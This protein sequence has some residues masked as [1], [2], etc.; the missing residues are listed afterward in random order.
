MWLAKRNSFNV[1]YTNPFSIAGRPTTHSSL[2]DFTVRGNF[3]SKG[4]DV[5]NVG[6]NIMGEYKDNLRV[7]YDGGKSSANINKKTLEKSGATLIGMSPQVNRQGKKVRGFNYSNPRYNQR[8]QPRITKIQQRAVVNKQT[9]KILDA[10]KLVSA[11]PDALK[12][13]AVI[14][15]IK[16]SAYAGTNSS[17]NQNTPSHARLSKISIARANAMKNAYNNWSAIGS[18]N[19]IL[20][21]RGEKKIYVKTRRRRRGRYT[22]YLTGNP[23]GVLQG[24]ANQQATV[25]W[26]Q[27]TGGLALDGER[28]VTVKVGEETRRKSYTVIVANGRRVSGTS[29]YQVPI[30][31]TTKIK[32]L[33]HV[34]KSDLLMQKLE[35]EISK[36]KSRYAGY[37]KPDPEVSKYSYYGLTDDDFEQMDTHKKGLISNINTINNTKRDL[38]NKLAVS[39]FMD[40]SSPI[41]DSSPKQTYLKYQKTGE[42]K[43]IKPTVSDLSS[44][45]STIEKDVG[46]QEANI[47]SYEDNIKANLS[48][49]DSEKLIGGIQGVIG[50][51][52]SQIKYHSRYR[53]RPA[54]LC[55]GHHNAIRQAQ[56][57]IGDLNKKISSIK[58]ANLDNKIENIDKF[59]KY[60]WASGH[61]SNI[62]SSQ[63]G[64]EQATKNI[65]TIKADVG[66]YRAKE[67]QNIRNSIS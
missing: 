46:E 47:K 53:C 12:T 40:A 22:T 7:S 52:Q 39:P 63:K 9:Q 27:E 41:D 57:K 5:R 34:Q 33:N 8:N 51:Q 30:Y 49:L 10:R 1:D 59:K 62:E 37:Y 60:G 25:K 15:S 29:Y 16:N 50:G 31:K 44:K 13:D 28:E 21:A 2:P 61:V 65:A 24:F 32:N 45:I 20:S 42:D 6:F 58:G 54:R 36:K 11:L 35:G 66:G 14:N 23:V 48:S 18:A 55:K 38:T 19:V 26:A 43:F 64:I 4:Y 17:N 67:N 3:T 56:T